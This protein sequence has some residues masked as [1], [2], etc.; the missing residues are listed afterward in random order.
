M[1]NANLRLFRSLWH[2]ALIV[3]VTASWLF[4]DPQAM[5]GTQQKKAAPA[6]ATQNT[7]A[8]KTPASVAPEEGAAIDGDELEA[9]F[10]R[11]GIGTRAHIDI[12]KAE[13]S[14]TFASPSGVK[15]TLSYN[16]EWSEPVNL[17]A[18][19]ASGEAAFSVEAMAT[20]MTKSDDGGYSLVEA[21]LPI[22]AGTVYNIY[23]K[24]RL[25]G[26]LIAADGDAPLIFVVHNAKN[27]EDAKPGFKTK[28]KLLL[29]KFR[30]SDTTPAPRRAPTDVFLQLVHVGG[31]GSA[32]L[33]NGVH[34]TLK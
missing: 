34:L 7:S 6:S 1:R 25:L 11:Q 30:L 8:S 17:R 31:R 14:R 21:N 10:A 28:G 19:D 5:S 12:S 23:G 13:L 2:G 16:H 9:K 32:T 27:S 29:V 26:N 22:G 20:Q 4:G 18:F 15:M 3:S 33:N 24:V